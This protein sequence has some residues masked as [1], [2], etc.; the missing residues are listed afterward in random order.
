[1]LSIY[2]VLVCFL[3]SR[4]GSDCSPRVNYNVESKDFVLE[5][6][7]ELNSLQLEQCRNC[8][9]E[10]FLHAWNGYKLYASFVHD[11]LRPLSGSFTDWMSLSVSL[12]SSLDTLYLLDLKDEF[13]EGKEWI[14]KNLHFDKDL[15]VSLF[16]A[17]IRIIGG[18][19]GAYEL[20]YEDV[21]L[22]KAKEL[23]DRLV[24]AFNSSSNI[25][26]FPSVNLRTGE[27]F[28]TWGI[29]VTTLAE[30]GSIQLEFNSLSTLLKDERYRN[31]GRSIIEHLV[32][33]N[34]LGGLFP[35]LY[36]VSSGQIS[37]DFGDIL[38]IGASADSFYEYLL[39]QC[40]FV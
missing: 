32:G 5:D 38:T 35:L 30:I 21:F 23:A 29:E 22:F 10:T 12:I 17:T 7:Q 37:H 13:Q 11:E 16:E 40:T 4:C 8:I 31:Y 2:V 36:H 20:S 25:L 28:P 24:L 33:L 14:V 39:K 27:G 6:S 34:P 26:P 9:R 3:L 19:L 15:N 1:M 18:F